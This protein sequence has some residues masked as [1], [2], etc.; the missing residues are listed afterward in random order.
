MG[1]KSTPSS[2][3]V[4]R[5]RIDRVGPNSYNFIFIPHSFLGAL[6]NRSTA[7]LRSNVQAVVGAIRASQRWNSATA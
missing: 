5:A 3:S 1:S 4:Q 2:W 7:A 6:F